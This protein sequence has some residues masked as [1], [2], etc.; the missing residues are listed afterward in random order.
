VGL[1]WL[2]SA[3]IRS[4]GREEFRKGGEDPADRYSRGRSVAKVGLQPSRL[5]FVRSVE[6]GGPS[7][8]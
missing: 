4:F 5:R 7:L 3:T 2:F 6:K 8:R 1:F